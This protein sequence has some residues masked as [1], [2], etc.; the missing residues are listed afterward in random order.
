MQRKVTNKDLGSAYTNEV[1]IL[2]YPN[3]IANANITFN[4]FKP[5]DFIAIASCQSKMWVATNGN[6]FD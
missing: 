4:P 5:L 1:R 2:N 3:H 6:L